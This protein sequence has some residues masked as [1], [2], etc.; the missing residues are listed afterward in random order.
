MFL[1]TAATPSPPRP[2]E[3]RKGTGRLS[4]AAGSARAPGSAFSCGPRGSGPSLATLRE[5]HSPL[6]PSDTAPKYTVPHGSAAVPECPRFADSSGRARSFVPAH[7]ATHAAQEGLRPRRLIKL[8]GERPPGGAQSP[9]PASFYEPW[10]YGPPLTC[11]VPPIRDGRRPR[12]PHGVQIVAWLVSNLSAWR[13][14]T[15]RAAPCIARPM[16][17]TVRPLHL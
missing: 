9:V 16:H 15:R 11:A 14:P 10:G 7:A 8:R 4:R 13:L 12:P 2:V 5:G 1:R 17:L 3:A 6:C